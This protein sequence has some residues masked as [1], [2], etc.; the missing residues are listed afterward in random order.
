MLRRT[1]LGRRVDE[2]FLDTFIVCFSAGNLFP[3]LEIAATVTFFIALVLCI[4]FSACA[5]RSRSHNV[6]DTYRAVPID[7]G[8]PG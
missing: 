7:F 5:P 6:H 1:V 4:D 2:F 3:H 8:R